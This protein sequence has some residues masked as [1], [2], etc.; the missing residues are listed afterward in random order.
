M[1]V[2]YTRIH[3][4]LHHGR[5]HNALGCGTHADGRQGRR[6]CSFAPV[7]LVVLD[8]FSVLPGPDDEVEF[9]HGADAF[10]PALTSGPPP[11]IVD[12]DLDDLW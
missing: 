8:T 3:D 11:G 12:P 9:L 7:T 6:Y 10:D 4:T 5:S 2:R 1:A